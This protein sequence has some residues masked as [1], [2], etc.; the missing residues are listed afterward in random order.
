MVAPTWRTVEVPIM[1]AVAELTA[2]TSV[3]RLSSM[4]AEATQ[5]DPVEVGLAIG[6]LIDAG[7]LSAGRP[8]RGG[9]LSLYPG[10]RMLERGLRETGV[11]PKEEVGVTIVNVLDEQIE[12]TSDPDERSRLEK[13]RDAA[14]AVGT[15]VLTSVVTE[16]VKRAT[17]GS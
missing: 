9:D 10:V 13:L 11:W 12:R 1:E 6:R 7:Y 8:V 17:L 16:G 15:S 5:L 14:V 3:V 4:I 2:R